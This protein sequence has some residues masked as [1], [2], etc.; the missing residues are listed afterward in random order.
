MTDHLEEKGSQFVGSPSPAIAA[1]AYVQAWESVRHIRNERIW[2][3]NAYSAIVAGS[4]AALL[5][6]NGGVTSRATTVGLLV[7]VLFSFASL[8]SSIRLVAELRNSIANVQRAVDETGMGRMVGAIE[9]LSGFGARLPMRWLF[10]I[11]YSLST[12]ALTAL[13]VVQLLR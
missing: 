4:L 7:L 1:A 12:A 13:F 3:T 11:Y 9:P 8:M 2:F 5:R 6:D 10:P